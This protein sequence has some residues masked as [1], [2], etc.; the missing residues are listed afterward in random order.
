MWSKKFSKAS[1][2]DTSQLWK[3][4][5]TNENLG[6]RNTSKIYIDPDE[7]ND[8]FDSIATDPLC[9]NKDVIEAGQ[10]C[11]NTANTLHNPFHP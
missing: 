9:N 6:G 2:S 5:Q 8:Y 11:T 3:L 4:L 10:S 7:I 1:N